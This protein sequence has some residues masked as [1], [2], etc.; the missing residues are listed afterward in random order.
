MGKKMIGNGL[1][2]SD[3]EAIVKI[4]KE[5]DLGKIEIK[6]GVLRLHRRMVCL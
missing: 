4:V 2:I 5:N 3:L 6:N 1:E